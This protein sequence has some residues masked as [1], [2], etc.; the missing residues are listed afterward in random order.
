MVGLTSLQVLAGNLSVQEEIATDEKG[1]FTFLNVPP[2]QALAVYGK[3]PSLSPDALSPH[4][5]MS[6]PDDSLMDVG[7]L[8]IGPGHELSGRVVLT[9]GRPL[10]PNTRLILARS[11]ARGDR[12]Q[13]PL[14]GDGSFHV[15]GIPTEAVEL[16][17]RVPGYRLSPRTPGYGGYAGVTLGMDRDL[18]GLTIQLEPDGRSP[19]P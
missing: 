7:Q 3:M 15:R 17:L 19:P 6:A 8:E 14:Q 12:L 5:F 9:D 1:F 11:T 16:S 10:P 18:H 2:Q 4:P 13:V